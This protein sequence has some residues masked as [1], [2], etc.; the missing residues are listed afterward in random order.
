MRRRDRRPQSPSRR[1]PCARVWTESCTCNCRLWTRPQPES[2]PGIR[3][4]SHV[5]RHIVARAVGNK[6]EGV[7]RPRRPLAVRAI[8]KRNKSTGSGSQSGARWKSERLDCGGTAFLRRAKVVSSRQTSRSI[9]IA[10]VESD[11]DNLPASRPSTTSTLAPARGLHAVSETE[12]ASSTV[13]DDGTG[14]G[15]GGGAGCSAGEGD[16]GLGTGSAPSQPASPCAS[17]TKTITVRR[18]LVI[19]VLPLSDKRKQAAQTMAVYSWELSPRQ[20]QS[21]SARFAA[22]ERDRWARRAV[23]TLAHLRVHTVVNPTRERG[24]D[25]VYRTVDQ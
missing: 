12:P 10:P 22:S 7:S 1:N 23:V 9:G 16:V 4:R 5:V 6:C 15:T 14:C 17:I 24:I 25:G 2:S 20:P 21:V 13:A 8:L 11:V 18:F 3:S 19:L